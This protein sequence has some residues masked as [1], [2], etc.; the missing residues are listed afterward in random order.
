[1][2]FPTLENLYRSFL[3]FQCFCIAVAHR[4]ASVAP[5][6]TQQQNSIH[7]SL[8]H[9]ILNFSSQDLYISPTLQSCVHTCKTLSYFWPNTFNPRICLNIVTQPQLWP[10]RPER[11]WNHANH[12]LSNSLVS[13][14]LTCANCSDFR[15]FRWNC[16][17]YG[18]K[19]Q[20]QLH[21]QWRCIKTTRNSQRNEPLE[22]SE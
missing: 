5:T 12:L 4:V 15:Q 8:P 21:Q 10:N 19:W 17:K 14:V 1:M 6:I 9:I 7:A 13:G 20:W 2:E 18:Q 11:L 16:Y 3:V 22:R